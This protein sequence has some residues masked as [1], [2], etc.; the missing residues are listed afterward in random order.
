[1]IPSGTGTLECL[2]LAINL[3][4]PPDQGRW[5]RAKVARA[6]TAAMLLIVLV[7]AYGMVALKLWTKC[8]S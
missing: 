2:P 5:L 6:V 4:R 8:C 1:M 3:D 7:A